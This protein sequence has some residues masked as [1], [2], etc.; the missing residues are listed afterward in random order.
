MRKHK[1]S[2]IDDTEG[3]KKEQSSMTRRK[4]ISKRKNSK[5]ESILGNR[6]TE[7]QF[8]IQFVQLENTN[9]NCPICL[10]LLAKSVTTACGH[11]YCEYCLNEYLIFFEQCLQC[12]KNLRN[13]NYS[14]NRVLDEIVQAIVPTMEME[15][16]LEYNERY[17]KNKEYIL[18]KK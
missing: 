18:N 14:Y 17:Q 8:P 1:Q 10:D 9:H 15:R 12:G 16:I 4:R 5:N 6:Q 2:I 3:E 7:E 11:S 13:H